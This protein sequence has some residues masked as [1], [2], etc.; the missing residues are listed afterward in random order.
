[1]ICQT[2]ATFFCFQN[3]AGIALDGKVGSEKT[4]REVFE[5]TFATNVFGAASL[6]DACLPLL[7]ESRQ[8]GGGRIVN[9]SS[10]LGSNSILADPD[11]EYKGVYPIVSQSLPLPP[12]SLMIRRSYIGIQCL[13]GRAEFYYNHLCDEEP[14]PPRRHTR[15]RL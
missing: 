7:K 11:G 5:E 3:N 13:Q 12:R 6:S 10:G 2:E 1:M 8:E 9:V 4:L 15:S 14:R